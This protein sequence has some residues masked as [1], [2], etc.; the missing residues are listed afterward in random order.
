[1]KLNFKYATLVYQ[2]GI[3]N[4]FSHET[5]HHSLR[6]DSEPKASVCRLLLQSDFKTCESYARGLEDVGVLV[7]SA[8]CNKAGD[9]LNEHWNFSNF[10]NAPFYKQFRGIKNHQPVLKMLLSINNLE[11][12]KIIKR[13]S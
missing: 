4:V 3:A 10:E 12:L 1:M 7:R 6:S 8:W 5:D 11:G 2:A 9:I 13:L